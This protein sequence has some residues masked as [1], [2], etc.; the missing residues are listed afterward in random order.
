[1][2]FPLKFCQEN[3]RELVH[4]LESETHIPADKKAGLGPR[5]NISGEMLV[6]KDTPM[7]SSETP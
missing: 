7:P 5:L 6:K 3:W 4:Q 1:M 2:A